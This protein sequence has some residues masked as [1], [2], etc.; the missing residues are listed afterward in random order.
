MSQSRRTMRLASE[1]AVIVVSILLAFWIDAWWGHRQARMTEVT[2]LEA[3]REEAEQNRFALDR[4]LRRNEVQLIRTD[5]FLGMTPG[6]LRSLPQDSVTP[7]I[8]AMVVTW[9][10]DGDDSAAGLLLGSAGPITQHARE[11]RI[12]LARWVR[13]LDD[14]EE[15]KATVW[16]LGTDLAGRLALYTTE[17]AN[18]GQGL[19]YEVAAPLGPGLLAQLRG[20][21]QFVAA[22]LNKSHYQN[23]YVRELTQASALLD[24]LRALVQRGREAPL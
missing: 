24:S 19:L 12:V 1:A 21:D 18:G 14:M 3:I 22:L 20:D 7:W 4:M 13:I 2:V 8:S 10:Y 11:V 17:A 23:V 5:G 15:E 9:T 6:E 16:G